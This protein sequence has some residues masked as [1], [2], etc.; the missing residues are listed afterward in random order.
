[1]TG[2]LLFTCIALVTL[3]SSATA[4]DS[5][6]R[7][8]PAADTDFQAFAARFDGD[9]PVLVQGELI[10]ADFTGAEG[11]VMVRERTGKLYRAMTGRTSRLSPEFMARLSSGSGAGIAVRGYLAWDRNC[12]AGC[13]MAARDITFDTGVKLHVGT[14]APREAR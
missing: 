11:V 6:R 1:M 5:V 14:G 2:R 13:L 3:T 4:Q 12:A 7:E 8:P 9:T 10:S